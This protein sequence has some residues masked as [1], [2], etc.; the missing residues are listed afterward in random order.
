MSDTRERILDTAESLAR[1]RGFNGFSYRDVAQPLGIRNAAIHYH[2]PTKADLGVA[3]VRRYRD[4]LHRQTGPFMTQ[5]GDPVPQLEGLIALYR[6][7]ARAESMCPVASVAADFFTLPEPMRQEAQTL[8]REMIVWMTRVMEV[9]RETNAL[10]YEGAPQ[11]KALE[12]LSAL[13]GA[14][15]LARLTGLETLDTAAA[16]LRRDLGMAREPARG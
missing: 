13:N 15:Q 2:F 7:D 9:G 10:R 12:V 5:G 4:L 6:R 11:E 3:L 14:T 8:A 16:Q 1:S